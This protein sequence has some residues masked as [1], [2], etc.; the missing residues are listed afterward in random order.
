MV[1]IRYISVV[2]VWILTAV[3]VVGS[4]GGTGILWWLYVD[5]SKSVNVTLPALELEVAKDNQKALLIYAIAATV[6]TVIL[7]LLMFFM[8]KRVA[9]TIALFHVAGK[10]FT[11][12]SL[13][14]GR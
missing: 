12:P 10:V 2:L 6:F 11:S 8:R 1:V 3:V 9:L 5:Q 14:R 7:L 13:S 4:I